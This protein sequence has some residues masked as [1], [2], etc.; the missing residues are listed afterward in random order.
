MIEG[1]RMPGCRILS[2]GLALAVSVGGVIGVPVGLAQPPASGV[3]EARTTWARPGVAVVTS[4]PLGFA[5][6]PSKEPGFKAGGMFTELLSGVP[7]TLNP[8]TARK[9]VERR[10]EGL[11]MQPLARY[12][13]MTLELR[14]ILASA[15]QIDPAGLWMRVKLNERATFSDGKPVTAEDVRFSLKDLY[16]NPKVMKPGSAIDLSELKSVEVLAGEVVELT[17]SEKR[18][19]NTI[20]VLTSIAIFPKHI[21]SG[22]SPEELTKSTGFLVGSGPFMMKGLGTDPKNLGGQWVPGTTEIVLT[23]NENYWGPKPPLDAVRFVAVADAGARLK[24]FGEPDVDAMIPDADQFQKVSGDKELLK[25][26]SP[27]AVTSANSLWMGVA[28]QCG[29]K[30]GGTGPTTPFASQDVRRAMAILIDGNE[31]IRTIFSGVGSP[32]T[33]PGN[34]RLRWYDTSLAA[35]TGPVEEAKKLL[36]SA[37]WKDRDG[38]GTVEN[39]AGQ[40]FAFEFIYENRESFAKLGEYL[41][42]RCRAV[43]V[44]CTGTGLSGTELTARLKART[45]DAATVGAA[46]AMDWN[47]EM[48][49]H[50]KSA[51][52]EGRNYWQWKSGAA[53]ALIDAGSAELDITMRE[54]TWKKLHGVIASEQPVTFIRVSP[55]LML[56]KQTV[57]NVTKTRTGVLTEEFFKMAE[58]AAAK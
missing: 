20:G 24:R 36:A 27:L 7:D 5:N 44:R 46:G 17:F 13:P 42:A 30:G 18:L 41:A 49:W 26:V 28:W 21:Y 48:S 15:W 22:M 31:V 56:V 33:G 8:L 47:P 6:D 9:G 16:A 53:D 51:A 4:K 38:D 10:A 58:P 45:F 55:S 2:M 23:R 3:Q 34:P 57:G 50:S 37:G 25:T 1:R 29:G 52:G 14:G 54:A 19:T 43:G 32:I 12:D 40:P 35:P 39:E 11:V